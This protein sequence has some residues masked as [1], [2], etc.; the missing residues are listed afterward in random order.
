M[1]RPLIAFS[2]GSVETW[3]NPGQEEDDEE[4]VGKLKYIVIGGDA[5]DGVGIFPNQEFELAESNV[6]K[7]YEMVAPQIIPISGACPD[8]CDPWKS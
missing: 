8:S 6:Y 5:V 3:H 2:F 7:Q 4:I 1:K